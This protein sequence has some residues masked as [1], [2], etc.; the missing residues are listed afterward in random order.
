MRSNIDEL[1]FLLFHCRASPASRSLP[2]RH[3]RLEEREQLQ[4]ESIA[5]EKF[6][7]IEEGF[8]SLDVLT[9]PPPRWLGQERRPQPLGAAA[10]H[11]IGEPPKKEKEGL[12]LGDDERPTPPMPQL[13]PPELDSEEE[14]RR[15]AP[16]PA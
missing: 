12:I 14:E 2:H 1:P 11:Q 7:L 8:A 4:Q 6:P 15:C 9:E 3:G 5:F 16:D 10:K 13:P